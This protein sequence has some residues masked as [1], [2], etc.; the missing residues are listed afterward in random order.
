MAIVDKT[1]VLNYLKI[2]QSD[3][4][5]TEMIPTLIDR[6]QVDMES[7]CNCKFDSAIFT[8]YHDG[9]GIS[10]LFPNQSPIT[11]VTS[12]HDDSSWTWDTSTLLAS[13]DY[14]I[15]NEN[16]IVFKS[17]ILYDYDQNIKIVYTAGYSSATMPK[18]L[19]QACIKEVGRE[20]KHR[21]DYD[22]TAKT[23]EDGSV[24][25]VEKGFLAST[26]RVLGHYKRLDLC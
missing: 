26:K 2:K 6:V 17:D 1:E 21:L 4:D 10:K 13:A 24:T 19:K 23:L 12:I 25:Y 8:E 14:R 7:Y 22:I 3:D 5:V 11:D 9:Q 18:D 16:I 15:M 20:Y